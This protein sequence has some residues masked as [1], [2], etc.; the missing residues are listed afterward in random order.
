M[1]I[2]TILLGAIPIVLGISVVWLRLEKVINALKETSDLL[3]SIVTAFGDKELTK[4]EIASIKKEG[5]E[6]VAALKAIFK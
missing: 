6:A 2:Q 4:E 1:D 5:I 3:T